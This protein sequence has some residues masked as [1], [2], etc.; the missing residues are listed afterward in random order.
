M[1]E[2]L[3][4]TLAWETVAFI[5]AFAASEFIGASSL[6]SNGIA[7]L[8]KNALDSYIRKLKPQSK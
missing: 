1:I 2:I 8:L 3:G 5:G 7:A 6:K 4:I